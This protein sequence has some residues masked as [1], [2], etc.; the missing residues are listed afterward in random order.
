MIASREIGSRVHQDTAYFVV[1]AIG[2]GEY[3][4]TG[5]AGNGHPYPVI[6]LKT[7]AAIEGFFRQEQLHILLQLL[8]QGWW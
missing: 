7:V 5:V 1:V 8:F 4:Q 6:H 3:K 2:A